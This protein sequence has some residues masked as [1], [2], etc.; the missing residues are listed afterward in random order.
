MPAKIPSAAITHNA[1]MQQSG[2]LSNRIRRKSQI[3]DAKADFRL[4]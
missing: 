1:A 2:N 3:C 4:T